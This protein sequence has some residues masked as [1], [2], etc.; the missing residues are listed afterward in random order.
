MLAGC[1]YAVLLRPLRAG[2]LLPF[3]QA[4]PRWVQS[5]VFQHSRSRPSRCLTE[6]A[7]PL[8]RHQDNRESL[9]YR[10]GWRRRQNA[11]RVCGS[12][13]RRCR[14]HWQKA[15]QRRR[16]LYRDRDSACDLRVGPGGNRS[17]GAGDG[18]SGPSR[19]SADGAAHAV[20][21]PRQWRC[22]S[23][24]SRTKGASCQMRTSRGTGQTAARRSWRTTDDR[25]PRVGALLHGGDGQR[26]SSSDRSCTRCRDWG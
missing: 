23:G 8:S 22:I 17:Y 12:R 6:H 11:F 16:P 21:L 25:R 9:G 2:R 15:E 13:R 18:S 5:W 24:I 26:A 4:S 10:R 14:L 3:P 20:H 19:R 7:V 1:A